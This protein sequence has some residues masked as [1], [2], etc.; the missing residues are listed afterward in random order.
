M[1]Q[2]YSYKLYVLFLFEKIVFI[3]T[4]ECYSE[5]LKMLILS[6]CVTSKLVKIVLIIDTL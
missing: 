2:Y 1:K 4:D 6:N 5:M 3:T